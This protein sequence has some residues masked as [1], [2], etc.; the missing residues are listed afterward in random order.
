MVHTCVT[1]DGDSFTKVMVETHI[2]TY[3]IPR[4]VFDALQNF[5]LLL[6]ILQL[7]LYE[8]QCLQTKHSKSSF[9]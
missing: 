4:E 1:L 8:F 6:P 9:P 7:C 2:E 5:V 3:E